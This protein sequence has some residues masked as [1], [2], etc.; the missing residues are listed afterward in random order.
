MTKNK[1]IIARIRKE[2]DNRTFEGYMGCAAFFRLDWT[3]F[4]DDCAGQLIIAIGA[5]RFREEVRNLA[6]RAVSYGAYRVEQRRLE[7]K[8]GYQRS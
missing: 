5:N 7:D 1:Q 8:Y 6:Q 4:Y 2:L 3:Q